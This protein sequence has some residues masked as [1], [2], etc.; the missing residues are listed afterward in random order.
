MGRPVKKRRFGNT[1]NAGQQMQ[2][3]AWLPGDTQARTSYVKSQL[4]SRRYKVVNSFG[5]GFVK[6]VN[7]AP[8]GPGT[9]TIAVTP[10]LG[11]P[12][13][14]ARTIYDRTVHT[15]AGNKYVWG[16]TGDTIPTAILPKATIASA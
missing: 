16:F 1:A 13:E 8:T 12:T 14:Y 10:V 3:S 4:G 2:V 6:L 11:G 15:F 9:A 7:T 5:T